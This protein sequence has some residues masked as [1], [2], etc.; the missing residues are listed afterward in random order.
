VIIR[1]FSILFFLF[2]FLTCLPIYAFRA[3]D[4]DSL[5]SDTSIIKIF[6]L[7]EV[8]VTSFRYNNDIRNIAA[9]IQI[10]GKSK[11]GNNDLGDISAVLNS[12]PG[13]QM[14]SGTFQTTKITI[15]GIGSRSPYS[16]NRARAFLDDIPLTTGD[17][18][19]V[20]DDI[21]LS[22]IDQIEVTKGPHSAWYG[23][24][25]GGSLRFV[26]LKDP[27]KPFTAETN[28][29]LGSFGLA[30][31]NGNVRFS[32]KA[33]YLNVGIARISGDGYRQNSKFS[34][35]SVFI[36]GQ[37]RNR[38]KLNYLL[39]YSD[40]NSQTPSSID[41]ETFSNTPSLA[42]PNW[43]NVKGHKNY[44]R[45]LCGIKVESPINQQIK[46]RVTLSG[47]FY[48]QYELRPFNILDDEALSVN[49]QE[50]IMYSHPL[51]SVATGFEWLHENYFWSILENNTLIEKQKSGEARNQLNSYISLETKLLPSLILSVTGNINSTHYAISDLFPADSIDYSGVYSNKLIFSPKIGLN[52]RHNSNISFYTSVGQGFSN[53]T[54]EE[55][56]TSYGFLNTSLK[57]EQ[58][59]TI[60]AGVRA[61]TFEHTLSLEASV[62]YI[63]LN[64]LLVTKRISE[65]IFYGEN[66]GKST[67]KGI[68]FQLK[69]KP[70]PYFQVL[71][72]TNKTDNRFNEFTSNNINFKNNQLPGIPDLNANLDLQTIFLKR[73]QL[74]AIYTYTGQQFMND[75]N[76]KRTNA[77]QTINLRAG[78]TVQISGKYQIQC[79]ASINNLFDEKYASMILIN[80][81]S[82]SG[83]PPR[84]Y[85]PALPR[86]FL[87]TVKMRLN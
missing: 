4:N 87:F 63:M 1:S 71:A 52:Y 53:P 7:D 73:F 85:Y 69:Y 19:T 44:Q 30:K 80:A 36:S 28:I 67:L 11:I 64:D 61:V 54:V 20:I 76:S 24:G 47:S 8:V 2:S 10:I 3:A 13:L 34:R 40:V 59:W 84:Y 42:A 33:G 51:F 62:Y 41:E 17:G 22:F 68:E 21:E 66:A 46:N 12:V 14:Q 86:N 58:G 60:D 81:P 56:L 15:R 70:T 45:L 6:D 77:W 50:N 82:F 9:P 31:F 16:S 74:N 35:N 26:S 78:Y 37:N 43:L 49:F 25:M 23:S 39:V 79:V 65:E 48:D 27:E 72:S 75:E 32:D 38:N 5:R 83:R 18:S 29:N 55:S 57:P